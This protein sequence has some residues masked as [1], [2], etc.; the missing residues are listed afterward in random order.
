MPNHRAYLN[1]FRQVLT[2][3]M[4]SVFMASVLFAETPETLSRAGIPLLSSLSSDESLRFPTLRVTHDWKVQSSY[5][6]RYDL[7]EFDQMQLS[8]ARFSDRYSVALGFTHRPIADFYTESDIVLSGSYRRG[9]FSALLGMH[10]RLTSI[11]LPDLSESSVFTWNTIGLGYDFGKVKFA[12]NAEKLSTSDNRNLTRNHVS[13][14]VAEWMYASD[15]HLL[16][17]ATFEK[18][19]SPRFAVAHLL[20]LGESVEA[21]LGFRSSPNEYTGGIDVGLGKVHLVYGAAIHPTL[22]LTHSVGLEVKLGRRAIPS[23]IFE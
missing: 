19:Q 12:A 21:S 2:V 20:P 1:F 15:L 6:R 11:S 17:S 5:E 10:A 18:L 7:P 23:G 4:F 16:A 22:G 8:A 9:R 14:L 3:A 13:H